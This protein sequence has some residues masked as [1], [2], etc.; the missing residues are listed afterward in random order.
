MRVEI[1]DN[2]SR[3]VLPILTQA[4]EGSMHSRIAVAFVSRTGLGLIRSA[5]DTCLSRGGDVEFLVGLDMTTS[6][7]EALWDLYRLCEKNK[8]VAMYCYA[9]LER[10][11]VYHPKLYLMNSEEEATAVVGSSNLTQGGLKKNVE[12]D[13]VIHASTQEE[14]VSDILAVYNKLKFHPQ[15]VE[16]DEE[17]LSLYERF[18]RNQKTIS[19]NL[20]IKKIS[21]DFKRKMSTLRRPIP[22]EK[23]LLGWQ[24]LIYS[25]LPDGDFINDDLYAHEEEFRQYY[26]ENRNIQAKIRQ[27]LQELR[28]MG[29]VRHVAKGH[30]SK[31]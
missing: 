4:I 6:E 15:R 31:A 3:K 1:A 22:T 29:L 14:I 20:D 10:S 26:P 16:A 30:W 19:R 11:S 21:A 17:L 9:D 7:P 24:Q 2:A 12:I 23:D 13:T 8:S 18:C 25:K 27:K 5:M 28:E